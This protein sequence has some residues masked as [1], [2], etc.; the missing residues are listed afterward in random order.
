MQAF[1]AV[2]LGES[3]RSSA[4]WF[5]GRSLSAG[6]IAGMRAEALRGTLKFKR[7][8]VQRARCQIHS[9]ARMSAIAGGQLLLSVS[10]YSLCYRQRLVRNFE[11]RILDSAAGKSAAP[12]RGNASEEW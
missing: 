7:A 3:R 2:K 10:M 8:P 1:L 11:R 4:S 9:T 5:N 6:A 12:T